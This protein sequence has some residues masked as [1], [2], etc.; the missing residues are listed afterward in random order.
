M[1]APPAIDR[2]A[3]TVVSLDGRTIPQDSS[4]SNVRG[5]GVEFLFNTSRR[6][7]HRGLAPKRQPRLERHPDRHSA[8]RKRC[9]MTSSR[10]PL[11]SSAMRCV[12]AISLSRPCGIDERFGGASPVQQGGGVV[13]RGRQRR[14]ALERHGEL[15][16]SWYGSARLMYRQDG[17]R[18]R[19]G[20]CPRPRYLR[21]PPPLRGCERGSRGGGLPECH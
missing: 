20:R 16:A 12:L 19:C 8:Q 3:R 10:S 18:D 5:G 7:N 11:P 9:A 1:Y 15:V 21:P 13:K 2:R 6:P 17:Q 14:D 4:T